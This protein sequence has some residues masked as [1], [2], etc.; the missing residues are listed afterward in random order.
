MGVIVI[1]NVEMPR[2][3]FRC[4]AKEHYDFGGEIRGWKCGVLHDGKIVSN[5]EARNHRRND[6]PL[7]YVGD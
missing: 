2:N 5:V 4:P 1:T 7:K 3:C 6:C